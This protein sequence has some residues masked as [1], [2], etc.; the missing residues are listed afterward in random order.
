MTCA[1]FCR[2]GLTYVHRACRL[3]AS[4]REKA[5]QQDRKD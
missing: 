2:K 5:S 3:E 4:A 1:T